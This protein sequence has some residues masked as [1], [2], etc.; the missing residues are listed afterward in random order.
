VTTAVE[1]IPPA[2]RRRSFTVWYRDLTRWSVNTFA[3]NSWAWEPA[4]LR[5]FGEVT[6]RRT[7]SVVRDGK[8]AHSVPLG[9]IHFDGSMSIRAA[10]SKQVVKG[11][12]FAAE[13]GDVVYSKIDARNGA[14]GLVPNGI[15]TLG[16]SAEY[17]IYAVD[18]KALDRDFLHLVLRSEHFRRTLNGMTSGTSGR[19]R[20]QPS[21]LELTPIPVPPLPAQR[22]IVAAAAK[23]RDQAARLRTEADER[24]AA[25]GIEVL[26]R[27]GL[28]PPA[29][30]GERP[31]HVTVWWTQ[32][33]R[34][35]VD[36]MIRMLQG[37]TNLHEGRFPVV[38]LGD[39]ATV[40]YGIQKSPANRP[41]KHPRPYLRVAN[42]QA[43][44]LDLSEMKYLDVPDATLETFRLKKGDLLVCEGNSADLVGRPAIWN[45]EIP[46]C[47]HQNHVLRVRVDRDRVIPE[48]L[49]A[50]MQTPPARAHFR[51]RAKRTTNL[52]TIN[53][54]DVKDLEVPCP[55]RTV[56]REIVR[57]VDREQE[58]VNRLRARANGVE[59][60]AGAI[61][62]QMILGVKQP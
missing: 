45:D 59:T 32:V 48:Y 27:L 23:A 31:R 11:R 28:K 52:S 37:S 33:E 17:P 14:V 39:I 35:G 15:G 16:F 38:T 44:R 6:R 9:S 60:Q 2:T 18:S 4:V 1:P 53:S 30:R 21:D 50:Y 54:R 19:K 29:V 8:G 51:A 20:I 58:A 10:T 24:E 36:Y 62:E 46:D 41:G 61:T 49:L 34:W 55:D 56:Q 25:I 12:L 3:E 5:T 13:P 47:V 26:R 42:V 7:V 22:R 43:G 40:S 57:E